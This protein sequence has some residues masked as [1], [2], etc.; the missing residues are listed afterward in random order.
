MP[1]AV[2]NSFQIAAAGTYTTPGVAKNPVFFAGV[3][4]GR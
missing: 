1:S 3:A 2:W 4:E